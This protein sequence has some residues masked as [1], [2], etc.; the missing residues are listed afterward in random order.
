MLDPARGRYLLKL[1]TGFA[2]MTSGCLRTYPVP[3]AWEDESGYQKDPGATKDG[4]MPKPLV[5]LG[6]EPSDEEYCLVVDPHDHSMTYRYFADDEGALAPDAE[7]VRVAMTT[8]GWQE[9][10]GQGPGST[11]DVVR[12][13]FAKGNSKVFFSHTLRKEARW[14][15]LFEAPMVETVV[16]YY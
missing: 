6:L 8:A 7:R 3:C 16:R 5:G 12:Q 2:L 4:S 11:S 14:A 9:A 15:D 1:C 10:A 13:T